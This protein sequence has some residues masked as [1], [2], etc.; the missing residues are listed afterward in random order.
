MI[1]AAGRGELE[2]LDCSDEKT[3]K[4]AWTAEHGD[5]VYSMALAGDA[6]LVGGAGRVTA[7]SAKDGSVV[8][9]AAVDGRAR[10]LAVAGGR[11]VV[12]TQEGGIYSF[13]A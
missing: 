3:I 5:R 6:V 8:W 12:S 11:L 9:R 1:Y 7:Y 13:A 10:G 4:W 2:A